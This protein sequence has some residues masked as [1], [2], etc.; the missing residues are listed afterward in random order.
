MKTSSCKAKGR[1]L[2]NFI[3]KE[4]NELY[5]GESF[6]PAIMGER[7]VDIKVESNMKEQFPYDIECKNQESWNIP[8][9]WKQT[10]INTSEDRKPLLIVKKNYQEPLVIMRWEDFKKINMIN[11]G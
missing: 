5:G 1:N 9:W 11:N 3:A 10:I 7:G 8:Q 6:R 4:L 2:Q